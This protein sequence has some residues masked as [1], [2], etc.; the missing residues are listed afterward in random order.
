MTASWGVVTGEES[1]TTV[2]RNTGDG[3]EHIAKFYGRGKNQQIRQDRSEAM[4]AIFIDAM[5]S[6]R[7]PQAKLREILK[8]IVTAV[9]KGAVRWNES[10]TKGHKF[11][12]LIALA[13]DA[14][15]CP[16]EYLKGGRP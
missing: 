14:M 12:G 13:T 8:A 2:Y 1:V 10:E 3:P 5:K 16:H 6:R 11:A 9:H 7:R 15:L 4:A